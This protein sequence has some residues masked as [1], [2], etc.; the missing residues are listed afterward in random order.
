MQDSDCVS[1]PSRRPRA[2]TQQKLLLSS[3]HDAQVGQ[4]ELRAK[5]APME[6]THVLDS[7]KGGDGDGSA[8]W[9]NWET[10]GEASINPFL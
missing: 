3:H 6:G 10:V 5:L 7:S 8:Y 1:L 2:Q 9:E 4:S